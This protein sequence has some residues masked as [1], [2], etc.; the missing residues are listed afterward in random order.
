MSIA[1]TTVRRQ[2]MAEYREAIQELRRNPEAGFDRLEAMGAVHQVS[3]KDRPEAVASAWRQAQQTGELV[4]VVCARHEEIASV[5]NA[6]RRQRQEAGELGEGVEVERY[7]PLNYTTAQKGDPRNFKVGQAVVFLR[8][9]EVM[10]VVQADGNKVITRDAVGV[11]R[12]LNHRNARRF[13]VYERR[14]IKIAPNDRLLLLANRRSAVFRATNGERVT[15]EKVEQGRIHLEDGRILPESYKEFDYGYAVTAHKS[16]GKSV[17]AVVISAD[18]MRRELFYV[19]ASRGRRAVTII[20]SDKDLLR[21]SV[22][23]S[24]ERQSAT[25]LVRNRA[26]R[27]EIVSRDQTME[28]EV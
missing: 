7:V 11:E 27:A 13:E 8:G 15:V 9:R 17:D 18:T 28:R 22:G 24:D 5:T 23:R 16:Q 14:S 2:T 20:T 1:L 4:L 10:T 19:A 6:I 21:D 12:E 25:E 3:W 26:V